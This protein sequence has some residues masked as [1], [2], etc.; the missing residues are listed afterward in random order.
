MGRIFKTTFFLL[1][2]TSHFSLLFSQVVNQPLNSDI[3]Q[4]LS[5]LSQRGVIELNDEI[6]PLSRKYIATK[7]IELKIKR[8]KLSVLEQEELVFYSQ[9]FG[10]EISYSSNSLNSISKTTL[11]EK[12]NYSRTRF[13]SYEDSL[14]A[15]NLSPLLGYSYGKN[16]KE[17]QTHLWKGFSIYGYLSDHI[18]YSF[19]FKDNSENG[20]NVDR[21]KQFTPI[22]GITDVEPKSTSLKYSDFQAMIG[23]DW[24]WGSLALGKDFIN[25]GYG[26]GGLL[27]LSSKAPSFPYIRLDITP[28]NWISFNYFHA[29]LES[30]VID[31]TG[32]YSTNATETNIIE[33]R[34]KYFASHTLT[35][36]PLFGL[37]LSIG[38]SVIYS[39]QLEFLY[40]FPLSFFRIADQYYSNQNKN[41][42][43]QTNFFISFSSRNHI[44]QTHLFTTLFMNE[45]A[46]SDIG[47]S[48]EV[49]PQLGFVFGASVTDL[50][51]DNLT[52][53]INYTRINPFAYQY[54]ISTLTYESKGYVLGH[55]IQHNSDQI[56]LSLNYRIIRGLQTKVWAE[57]IRKGGEGI[58]DDQF[59]RPP[60][61]FLFGQR[62]NYTNWGLNAKYEITHEAFISLDFKS[63]HTSKEQ[64]NGAFVDIRHNEFF[65]SMNYGL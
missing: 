50:P 17:K 10:R 60:Q 8:D 12:D 34:N 49:R 41:A 18:G 27:T 24:G 59:A 15:I 58:A 23:T 38:E 26:E 48:K 1:L 64:D 42:G 40:L 19:N 21:K 44:P 30:D 46:L 37:S 35:L 4:Y 7:L 16:D 61:P 32:I 51:I 3:Y 53:K 36:R 13:F 9:D 65:I 25:W 20:N 62:T 39:D 43:A 56:Y 54:Y 47:D 6:R 11:L 57:F 55:W 14:F 45:V 2:F 22:T 31:S 33:Y 63:F 28:T 5:R 29:W 52:I